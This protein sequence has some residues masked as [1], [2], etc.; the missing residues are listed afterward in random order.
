MNDPLPSLTEGKF[1]ARRL[2]PHFTLC[3]SILVALEGPELS[4]RY[5]DSGSQ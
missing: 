4:L 3:K 1:N 2:G 5:W